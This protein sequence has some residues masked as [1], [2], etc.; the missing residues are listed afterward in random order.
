MH[1][2]EQHAL[3]RHPRVGTVSFLRSARH[4]HILGGPMP[5]IRRF[6]GRSTKWQRANDIP[7]GWFVNLGIG[8][9]TRVANHIPDHMEIIL[10]SENGTLGYRLLLDDEIPSP[11]L[12]NPGKQP[13]SLHDVFLSFHVLLICCRCY[14]SDRGAISASQWSCSGRSLQAL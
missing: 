13:I 5:T 8:I 12:I 4:R 10:H 7:A 14:L 6:G 3:G 2:P 11:W 1:D 9:P